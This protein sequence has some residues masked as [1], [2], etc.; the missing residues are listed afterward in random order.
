MSIFVLFLLFFVCLFV[1]CS[2]MWFLYDHRLF[3]LI[4]LTSCWQ[5]LCSTTECTFHGSSWTVLVH[6]LHMRWRCSGLWV[7]ASIFFMKSSPSNI[8]HA[9]LGRQLH[10]GMWHTLRCQEHQISL[11][12]RLWS[13]S[14]NPCLWP[15]EKIRSIHPSV[16]PLTRYTRYM[17]LAERC[18]SWGT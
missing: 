15:A 16:L 8:P 3:I 12:R 5:Y 18:H 11:V 1:V 2:H 17:F 9:S 6:H 7:T 13:V 14:A 4:P 10:G